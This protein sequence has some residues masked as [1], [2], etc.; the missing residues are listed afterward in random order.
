LVEM[1][2]KLRRMVEPHHRISDSSPSSHGF[3]QDLIKTGDAQGAARWMTGH[4]QVA[5]QS[6]LA[7]IQS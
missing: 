6:Q 2:M 1:I 4:L 7:K 5:L 3:L